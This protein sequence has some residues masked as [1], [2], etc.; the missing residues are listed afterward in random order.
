MEERG[1]YIADEIRFRPNRVSVCF[2]TRPAWE[3]IISEVRIF[4][5]SKVGC[6][7]RCE[8]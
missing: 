1:I 4:P 3:L 2:L 8:V 6:E 5:E 7:V